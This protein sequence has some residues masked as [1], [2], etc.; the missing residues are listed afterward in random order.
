MDC[1]S[2][3]PHSFFFVFYDFFQNYLCRFYFLILSWLRIIITICGE[4]IVAFLTNYCGLLQCFLHIVFFM[5]FSKTIFVDF[6]FLI[7]SWLRITI[8]SKTKS[9]EESIVAFLTKH[10][11]L[12]IIV[13]PNMVFFS[14]FV[15][16]FSK[17]IFVDFIIL[18]LSWLEFSFII[19]SL[20]HCGLIQYFS[21]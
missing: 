17:I 6:I 14:F 10:C 18:I 7:L 11:G 13:F 1:Y 5:F 20:K 16:I 12:L 15:M 19:F 2:V 8:T 4:S 9:C 3:S 21:T